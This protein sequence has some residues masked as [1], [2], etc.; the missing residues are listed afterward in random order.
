MNNSESIYLPC[1]G[2]SL[3][4]GD[5]K[6]H[7][8]FTRVVNFVNEANEI[9]FI[10]SEI[11]LLAAHGIF[12]PEQSLKFIINLTITPPEIIINDRRINRSSINKYDSSLN[13]ENIDGVKF[14]ENLL[15]LPILF[16]QE[17]PEKSLLFL[18]NSQYEANF[19]SG[20]DRAFMINALRSK[21]LILSGELIKGVEAIKGTGYGLTPSGD[22][23]I[24]G[25]LLGMHYNEF[26]YRK[27]LY[28][29]KND[30]YQAVA[31]QNLLTSSF[32]FQAKEA[33]YFRIL[34]N[35][36]FLLFDAEISTTK[37]ELVQLFSLGATSGADLL[38]GYIF[39]IKYKIAI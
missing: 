13:F 34:K 1:A 24:A 22:D 11:S 35:F 27:N 19:T 15:Q 4:L 36:L 17:F 9:A 26:K 3:P 39:S 29:A 31:G 6:V 7:S 28:K 2:K 32:L 10:T 38:T 23:F 37:D 21:E 18:L 12:L 5:F 14:E 25:L 16:S 30:I 20:F 33:N 8:R